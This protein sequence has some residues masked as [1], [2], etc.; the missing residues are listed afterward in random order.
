MPRT[1]N[2]NGKADCAVPSTPAS[3]AGNP[4]HRVNGLVWGLDNWMYCANG[5]SG[6]TRQVGQ[7]RREVVNIRGRDSAHPPG[8][9]ADSMP[10]TGQ[11]QYGRSRDDWGNWFGN[12][13]SNP[14]YHFALADQYIRRNPHIAA[15]GPP[16]AGLGDAGRVARLSDQPHA[17]R[18]STIRG[19]AN[20]FTSACSA[21]VYRD[22][23]FGPAFANST[24]VSEPVHNL[25]HREIMT[26]SGRHVH[27]PAGRRRA[28]LGVPGLERQ[29][30]PADDDSDRAGRG[31]VDRRHVPAVIE[32]PEWIPKDWQKQ[33]RPAGRPRQGPYLPR[34]SGRQKPRPIPRLD[35]LDTAGLV[36]ALDSPS[37]WQRD[38]GP[39]DAAVAG[40]T[41][42][43]CRCWRSW[44]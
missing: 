36:A 9:R 10:Q 23:L 41:R 28:A 34:L 29:L 17:C 2:G 39:A 1:P 32:H 22:E 24:F 42:S 5:D 11:T 40:R 20:H 35:Q 33:A 6:G 4:Q 21:I 30:V 31:T 8:R 37:G 16:R 13:N 19:A 7:D 44:R 27:Q 14:M 43:P 12:N 18:A 15:P 26:R 3:I 25:V 38:T